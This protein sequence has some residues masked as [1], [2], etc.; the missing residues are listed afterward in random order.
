M[1]ASSKH[2]AGFGVPNN[3]AEHAAQV[4]D[5]ILAPV[6]VTHNDGLA[7]ALSIK[8]ITRGRELLTKFDVVIDFTV[9]GQSVALGIV[10]WAPAQRLVG[11]F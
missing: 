6:V 10:L 9:E 3:K 4:L 5:D 7:I 11:V 8:G 2:G 1:V